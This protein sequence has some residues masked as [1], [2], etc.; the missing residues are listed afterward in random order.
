[1]KSCISNGIVYL[2]KTGNFFKILSIIQINN[3]GINKLFSIFGCIT[4]KLSQWITTRF[5]IMNTLDDTSN[6]TP[7][8]T[9][10]TT[11][12]DIR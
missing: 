11:Q 3:L 4:V 6:D 2:Y 10:T 9:S 12:N 7:N 8:D 5:N 1:M